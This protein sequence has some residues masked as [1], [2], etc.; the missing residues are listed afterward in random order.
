MKPLICLLVVAFGLVACS[1]APTAAPTPTPL[2]YADSFFFGSAFIDANGNS[3]LDASDPPLSGAR[4]V[5]TDGRGAFAS[6]VTDASGHAMAWFP[7]PSTFPITYRMEPPPNSGYT[8]I[9][10]QEVVQHGYTE[11]VE[12]RFLF[13]PPASLA[14]PTLAPDKT[15]TIRVGQVNPADPLVKPLLGVISGPDPSYNSP[16]ANLTAQYRDIGVTSVRN[17]DYYDDRLDI[18]GIFN[19][20]GAT[21]PSW[22]GCDPQND[23][24][25]RWEA[26]DKQFQSYLNGG[27]EPFFRLGGEWE[28]SARHHD[29]KGPQNRAQEQNWIA[30]AVKVV[31]RYLHWHSQPNAF[32]YLDIWTEFPGER[33]WSRNAL[34]FAPFWAQVYTRLKTAYPSLKIGGP[35]FANLETITL[36]EGKDK[37]GARSFLTYLYQNKIKPDWIGWHLFSNDPAMFWRAAQAYEELL[38]GKG[39]YANVPWAG[40]GYF[41][42]VQVIV[43]AYGFD[44]ER[45]SDEEKYRIAGKKEG[46]SLLTGAWIAMQ[47]RDIEQAYYYRGGDVSSDPNASPGKNPKNLPGSGLF[48]GDASGT[49]KPSAHAFRLWSLIVKQFPTLLTT[50]LPV[51][52]TAMPLWVLA[53]QN[54]RGQR[55]LLIANPT[56]QNIGW[57]VSFAD[58]LTRMQDYKVEIYQVDDQQNGRTAVAWGGGTVTIPAGGVQLAVLNPAGTAAVVPTVAQTPT[59]KTTAVPTALP[60]NRPANPQIGLNF[61]R[62]Y[63]SDK[64]GTLDTTTPYLQPD[65]IFRDFHDLGVHAYR[66]FIKADLLWDVVEPRDNQWN[67]AQADAVIPNAGF[68]PIVTLFRLQYASPTPPWATSPQQ[69]QKTLGVEATDYIETVVKRYAPYVKYW[70]IGNEMA[71]WRAADPSERGAKPGQ[72]AEKLPAAYPLD[73]YSP[74]EQGKF[75]AQAAA[76]I[77]KHDP[78]AIILLPGL[79]GL[80]EYSWGIWL[81]G[82]I[83]G[84]GKEMSSRGTR[85]WFDV[86]N[87]HYYGNW[88]SFTMLRPKFQEQL[89]KLGLDKKPLWCT[90]TGATSNPKLTLRT[91]Y[92]NSV[93]SQAADIFRRIVSA[94]GHG[95]AFVAWHTYISTSDTTGD[96][97]AYGIRTERGNPQPSF[98]AFKL[99]AHELVPFARVE[100]LSAD[101]RGVNAYKIT[102]QAGAVKY[103]VWGVGNYTL[104]GGVT[105]MTS[106]I[107][108][109]D[110]SFAW[111]AAQPGK[112]IALSANPVLIK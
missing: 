93:E 12:T 44:I 46:A 87:Y 99:L 33:F 67:F 38:G 100:K 3:T 71:F 29:F 80:D 52:N 35:G 61:I 50:E 75:L 110:G 103:V 8:L 27:F 41:D 81:P 104:P 107:P 102:T 51:Q 31:D 73:G 55:A 47:Y 68:E 7:A 84:G 45:L 76:L 53:A 16:A 58:G 77:R 15:V 37:G 92:P 54:D 26:S 90:E 11:T 10:P 79:P 6:G 4:F 2:V 30:A 97:S 96:W 64:P 36:A 21:Y 111:Q 78:D 94:W 63:W 56:A 42:N 28:N 83:E 86:V 17:N 95:D 19:C 74:R 106:V 109:S 85:D 82:V 32:T 22:E 39:R 101:A 24:F 13:A 40:T 23:R 72:G 43:D 18:E 1:T 9:T 20:G 98:Y 66:Q 88:E 34:D 57:T 65:A 25:Y 48:F 70:E 112:V 91:N 59:T 60:L 108:K 69:F 89:K 49:P 105:Q 5:V 62:F 14:A